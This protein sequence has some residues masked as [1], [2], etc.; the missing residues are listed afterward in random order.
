[1][2]NSTLSTKM[3]KIPFAGIRKVVE[4]A[5][6]IEASGRKVVHFEIG[7]PDFDT[8][9]HIKESAKEA[10]DNGLV[11]YAP[12]IGTPGLRSALVKA[13]QEYQG[14]QYNP[15]TEL[16]VTAGAQE[17]LLLCLHAVI[18]SGDEVLVPSPGFGQYY[19]SVP[20][21]GGVAVPYSLNPKGFS[22]DE[23]AAE[24]KI[25]KK[26]KV[27][28]INSPHNPTG[29]VLSK[30]ELASI[31]SFAERH[32]LLVISDEAYDRMLYDGMKH[33]TIAS[34]SGLKERTMLVGSF[35]KTY[36]MTGWRVGYVATNPEI[37]GALV[38]LQQNVMLSVCTFAQKG[39]QTALEDSQ[40]CVE[41]MLQVFARRREIVIE[42]VNKAQGLSCHEAP[43]GAFYLFVNHEGIG[44]TSQE[45]TDYLLEE[46]GVATVPGSEF[47]PDGEGHLRIS[48]ATSSE[49]CEL[50]MKRIA[51]ALETL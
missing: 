45:L 11:H 32:N 47:G 41:D 22:W 21:V 38:R 20:L 27:I 39:A 6:S 46:A 26:T 7:R 42:G 24:S 17:G 51:E 36:S 37:R 31:A 19:T 34:F 10:L 50:G 15:D 44:K 28:I 4:K 1:M 40:Q 18:N 2:T 23:N 49:D 14:V 8:P 35:S 5:R 9:L 3:D 13:L 12:N 25:T 48:Y 33:Y 30:E 16:M 29:A 43:R